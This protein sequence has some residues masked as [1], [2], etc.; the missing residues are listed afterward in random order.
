MRGGHLGDDVRMVTWY[1]NSTK[2]ANKLRI[3]VVGGAGSV[4]ISHNRE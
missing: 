1:R 2:D 4:G 3:E